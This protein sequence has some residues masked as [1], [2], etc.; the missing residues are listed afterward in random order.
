MWGITKNPTFKK[1]T[2]SKP[3]SLKNVLRY[4]PQNIFHSISL[5][6][7]GHRPQ[8][9]FIKNFCFFN[10]FN[11]LLIFVVILYGKSSLHNYTKLENMHYLIM[12]FVN[13]VR[14]NFLVESFNTFGRRQPVTGAETFETL[15]IPPPS[16]T[17][18]IV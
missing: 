13:L 15:K 2:P 6:S 3:R 4:P 5:V 10:N 9:H 17:A 7:V 12:Y 8:I 11:W 14:I 18:K 16:K 1:T